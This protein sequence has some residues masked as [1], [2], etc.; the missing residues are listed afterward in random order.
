MSDGDWIK[1]VFSDNDRV[2]VGRDNNEPADEV[3]N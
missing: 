1:A 2:K 3:T